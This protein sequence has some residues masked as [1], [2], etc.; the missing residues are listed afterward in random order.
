[1]VKKVAIL[2]AG[3]YAPCLS[4]AIGGLIA[5]YG[6]LAPEAEI[7]A[8]KHGY[9]GLLR[10]DHLLVTPAVRAKAHLLHRFGG[11]PIGN[12]RVKL[13]NTA[14]LVRRGLAVEGDN[15]LKVAAER[16]QRD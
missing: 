14:D 8:Y 10:G 12:S 3:G 15:P 13:T 6:A 5:R 11:S 4:S 9:E 7:I 16:L 1:M 2:T